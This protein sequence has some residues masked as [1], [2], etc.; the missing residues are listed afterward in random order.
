M[1]YFPFFLDIEG[2]KGLIVG[3]GTVALR[4]VEKLL[5]FS[6]RLTVA[7][8][9]ICPELEVISGLE[10]LRRPFSP[11]LLEGARFVIAATDSPVLNQQVAQLCRQRGILVNVVDDQENCTFLFPA[12]VK[13]GGLCVGVSTGGSSPSAAAWLRGRVEDLL[14]ESFEQILDYLYQVRPLVKERLPEESRA[15]AFSALFAACMEAG[16]PLDEGEFQNILAEFLDGP[17]EMP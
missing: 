17:E 16:R 14:P 4:K 7:A 15:A 6:P 5:P 12:L 13:R 10:L 9:E 2:Q 8:P 3:G 11:E 1:E